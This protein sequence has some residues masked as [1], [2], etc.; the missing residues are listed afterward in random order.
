MTTILIV[1]DEPDVLLLLRVL[2]EGEGFAV[3]SANDGVEALQQLAGGD[4]DLVVTDLMM[5]RMDGEELIR[6][7]R[8]GSD[9][10]AKLP[11]V[12]VSARAS[13]VDGANAVFPK[14]FS[15][16]ELIETCRT[17]VG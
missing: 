4:V 10:T 11:V 13:A 14:P 12:V 9:P 8:S 2:L 16:D 3:R 6:T 1:D 17:L 7:I 15:A 5:P